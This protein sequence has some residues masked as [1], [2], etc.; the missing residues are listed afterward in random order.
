MKQYPD[1]LMMSIHAS[2]AEVGAGT[3]FI[4]DVWC[5]KAIDLFSS[6]APEGS[7]GI[8]SF[9]LGATSLLGGREDAG[10]GALMGEGTPRSVLLASLGETL[11]TSIVSGPSNHAPSTS[12]GPSPAQSSSRQQQIHATLYYFADLS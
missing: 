4:L 5:H 10:Q 3:R 12:S 6:S 2:G 9:D 7:R 8:W 1:M 11:S